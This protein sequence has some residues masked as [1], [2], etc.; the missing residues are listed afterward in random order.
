M[1][2]LQEQILLPLQQTKKGWGQNSEEI[3]SLEQTAEK[4]AFALLAVRGI[5]GLIS[6]VI[7]EAAFVSLV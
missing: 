4:V 7:T 2:L 1:L 5:S 3:A 6:L